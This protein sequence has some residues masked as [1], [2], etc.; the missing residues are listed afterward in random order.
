MLYLSNRCH[1][2]EGQKIVPKDCITVNLTRK[3]SKHFLHCI[4]S[5]ILHFIAIHQI[6]LYY[7]TLH[8]INYITLLLYLISCTGHDS[9]VRSAKIL[10]KENGD[11][12]RNI[13]KTHSKCH[14]LSL[15]YVI[16]G[17]K[18]CFGKGHRGK[19]T[20]T[21]AKCSNATKSPRVGEHFQFLIKRYI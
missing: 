12:V 19:G 11:V 9:T 6:T 7:I 8:Y 2:A 15:V 21:K 17:K 13:H 14:E 4:T 5:H 1:Y 3:Y 18:F 16:G 20:W 10:R